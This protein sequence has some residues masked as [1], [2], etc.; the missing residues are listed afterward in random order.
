MQPLQ[1]RPTRV[2]APS[3]IAATARLLAHADPLQK[4]NHGN[5]AH[6]IGA[7]L[8]AHRALAQV[9]RR[10]AGSLAPDDSAGVSAAL[11]RVRAGGLEAQRRGRGARGEADREGPQV[12]RD[13]EEDDGAA[14]ACRRAGQGRVSARA[15]R[16][17]RALPLISLL[18]AQCN[19][20]SLRVD[21]CSPGVLLLLLPRC[22][23]RSL[24]CGRDRIHPH[25]QSM[26]CS[27]HRRAQS[28]AETYAC[29]SAAAPMA[30]FA[31]GSSSERRRTCTCSSAPPLT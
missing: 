6:A 16:A 24:L 31:A 25:T 4:P 26:A 20:S 19:S 29:K 5:S 10:L 28:M 13:E 27:I 9:P 2:C 15:E 14:G 21:G 18:W 1:C 3:V 12:P 23:V 30:R 7:G 8:E 22:K 17:R 11:A